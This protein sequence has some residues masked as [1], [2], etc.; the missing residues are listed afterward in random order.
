MLREIWRKAVKFMHSSE[1][2]TV[3]NPTE[4]VE[5]V[6]PSKE[7]NFSPEEAR[8]EL[9]K[10]IAKAADITLEEV[11]EHVSKTYRAHVLAHQKS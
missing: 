6:T 10:R 3:N 2:E 7:Y 5:E 11:P 1:T 4:I 8:K 9:H